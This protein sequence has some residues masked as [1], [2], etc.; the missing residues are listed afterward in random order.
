MTVPFI[1]DAQLSY[2]TWQSLER[3]LA[4]YLIY[5]GGT[6]VKIVGGA[7]DKGADIVGVINGKVVLIQSKFR[8]RGSVGEEAVDEAFNARK[9][10]KADILIIAT[11]QKFSSTAIK[12]EHGYNISLMDRDLLID[13]ANNE[14][15]L[16]LFKKTFPLRD[17][18]KQAVD[19][20]LNSYVNGDEKCLITLATG[21]GK[22]VVFNK[23]I[24]K[25]LEINVGRKVLV[26]AH[27]QDLVKQLE[28]SS[29][30]IFDKFIHTHLW[31]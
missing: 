13:H 17:Y 18:Q 11:N 4:R 20:I 27:M 9:Y 14:A 3:L 12:K 24:E 25:Y 8:I 21:L 6:E 30:H 15:I 23:F 2:G 19:N 28:I 1:N 5:R 26:L 16:P 31:K 10:Y 7:N 29:W 22:T